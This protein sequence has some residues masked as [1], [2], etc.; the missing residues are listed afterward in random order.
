MRDEQAISHEHAGSEVLTALYRHRTWS[1]RVLIAVAVAGLMWSAVTV[2][3]NLAPAGPDDPLY[4]FSYLIEAM[5]AAC[6]VIVMVGRDQTA[7]WGVEEDRLKVAAAELALLALTIALTVYPA[8]TEHL[9]STAGLHAIA[10]MMTAVAVLI[11][12]AASSRYGAAIA[13]AMEVPPQPPAE[14]PAAPAARSGR[15]SALSTGSWEP[16]ANATRTLRMG[17]GAVLPRRDPAGPTVVPDPLPGHDP[18]PSGTYVIRT[19]N[20]AERALASLRRLP[21]TVTP[22]DPIDRV[23]HVDL[24][25][26]FGE[27][28]S[29]N[30]YGLDD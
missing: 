19:K 12:D 20:D 23:D 17:G 26:V 27:P 30:G 15:A 21:P 11:H 22:D 28:Q 24:F 1:A 6:L 16:M 13:R 29:Y 4:W 7:P 5:V 8:A 10:P 2:Q 9:W 25:A 18:F 3:R 14:P